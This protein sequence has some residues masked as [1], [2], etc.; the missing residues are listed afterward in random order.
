MYYPNINEYKKL[1]KCGNLIPVYREVL[2]DTDTP[3]SAYMKIQDKQSF[4]LE[5]LSNDEK[6]ARYSFIGISPSKVIRSWG[7]RVEISEI[8]KDTIIKELKDPISILKQELAAYQAVSVDGLPPFYGGLVG[9][10]GYENV[11][12]FERLPEN[13]KPALQIPDMC[14]LMSDTILIFDHNRLTIKIVANTYI[15]N[16]KGCDTAYDE[17]VKKIDKIVHSLQKNKIKYKN[18]TS[19]DINKG[20]IKYYSSFA[21]KQEFIDKVERSKEYIKAG[22]IFQVVLSQRFNTKCNVDP[23]NIYRALRIINPSPYMFYFNLDDIKLVGASPEILV[24][25]RQDKVILRP[26]AGTRKRGLNEQ[27]DISLEKELLTD[28]KELAEHIMLVDL[29]RN[30][31]GRV[32]RFGSIQINKLKFI[33]RYSHVMHIVSDIEGTLRQGL[34]AFDVLAACFPAGTVTGA[35]K[36]R[37]MEIINELEPVKRGPYAGAVGYFSFSGDMD[38][39]ITIRTLFVN[40]GQIYFQAGAGIVADSI[41]ENEFDETL[42]KA[43]AV[44]RAIKMAQ[45]YLE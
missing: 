2:A 20:D 30:D 9:Y 4:L 37:A 45:D 29:G 27:E 32:T 23:F 19:I 12:Y 15:N 18:C 24:R 33:E 7:K 43:R 21:S 38:T 13:N 1:A 6:W 40:D 8:G 44:L 11:R 3:V 10:L 42:N 17:A 35:P 26:I 25:K 5:S 36:V 14:F 41:A 22:D 28:P 31:L 39:C 34:D 16:E